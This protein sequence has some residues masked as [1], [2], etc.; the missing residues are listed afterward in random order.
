MGRE[1]NV[2]TE[3]QTKLHKISLHA[4]QLT[5]GIYFVQINNGALKKFIK[6]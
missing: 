5:K 1:V 4:E 6:E 3:Q 2:Q